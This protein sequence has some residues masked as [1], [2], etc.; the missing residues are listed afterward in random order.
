MRIETKFLRLGEPKEL[1]HEIGGWRICWLGGWDRERI[2]NV[3][4]VVRLSP[5]ARTV[6]AQS[7][8]RDE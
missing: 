8:G 6:A 2:F 4:M 7:T 1:D 5:E 3:V